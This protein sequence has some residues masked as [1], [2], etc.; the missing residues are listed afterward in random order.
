MPCTYTLSFFFFFLFYRLTFTLDFFS[1][2]GENI[3]LCFYTGTAYR[4]Q[5][6]TLALATGSIEGCINILTVGSHLGGK[7]HFKSN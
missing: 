1:F 3:V 7:G 6:K 4:M 2:A 5:S